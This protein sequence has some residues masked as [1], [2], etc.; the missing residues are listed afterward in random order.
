[1]AKTAHHSAKQHHTVKAPNKQHALAAWT[2]FLRR[3]RQSLG[4]TEKSGKALRNEPHP[5]QYWHEVGHFLAKELSV[6]IYRH[7]VTP[8]MWQ[9]FYDAATADKGPPNAAGREIGGAAATATGWIS[10]LQIPTVVTSQFGAEEAFREAPHT[11]VDLRAPTGSVVVAPID[12]RVTKVGKTSDGNLVVR[13]VARRPDGLFP[14][15]KIGAGLNGADDSG[16]RLEFDHLTMVGPGV[17]EG[18]VVPQGHVLA[19]SGGQPGAEGAGTHTTAPHLHF[20]V[21]WVQEGTLLN[22]RV[23]INPLSLISDA[24]FEH[25]G[26]PARVPSNVV[27]SGVLIDKQGD[28]AHRE[29]S[30]ET[31]RVVLHNSGVIQI[32][33]N[34]LVGAS[35]GGIGGEGTAYGDD[36][37]DPFASD[38]GRGAGAEYLSDN[39]LISVV[40][41]ASEPVKR[42]GFFTRMPQLPKVLEGVGDL[43]GKVFEFVRSPQGLSLA[44]HAVGG[45][46]DLAGLAAGAFGALSPVLG[47]LAGAIP[48]VDVIAP[49]I[50]AAGPIADVAAPFLTSAGGVVSRGAPPSLPS[51]PGNFLP[52]QGQAASSVGSTLESL[53]PRGP[54]PNVRAILPDDDGM[55]PPLTN[56]FR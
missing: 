41:L 16:W 25:P 22:K 37:A 47:A 50:F 54:L 21:E 6:A 45:A 15:D 9:A 33:A 3:E 56:P 49:A 46:L 5:H 24:A 1:M 8:E 55:L 28:V 52:W 38:S 27:A 4:E 42:D 53:F 35:V 23:F 19:I 39:E 36:I 13:A 20:A 51:L 30:A 11:G 26:Q 12:L 17:G 43:A 31:V 29:A 2:G 44:S 18:V 48:Y 14:S 40:P 32:G 10:P 34:N 7:K